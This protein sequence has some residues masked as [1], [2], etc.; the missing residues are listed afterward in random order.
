M[1]F[2]TVLV[3]TLLVLA[4]CS[5]APGN[6]G[7]AGN[8]TSALQSG[9]ATTGES[10]SS[11]ANVSLPPGVSRTGITD[12]NGLATAHALLLNKNSYTVNSTYVERYANGTTRVATSID[13]QLAQNKS[14]YYSVFN[15]SGNVE[16]LLGSPSGSI[17]RW[18]DGRRV[19][20][21]ATLNNST[22]YKVVYDRR[23]N[24]S[25]PRAELFL[26]PTSQNELALLFGAI[27]TSA[28]QPVTRNGTALFRFRS[29]GLS[30]ANLF[31]SAQ[32]VSSPGNV[33]FVAYVD[34]RGLVHE[35]SLS[36]T[37]R[38]D[39]TPI[40]VNRTVR[41][42]DVGSTTVPRPNW[43]SKVPVNGTNA[44]TRSG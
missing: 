2:R 35:Y 18:S 31:T 42:S 37:A 3:A 27:N 13:A 15:A 10:G 40:T 16:R 5:G 19:Y 9:N 22:T 26:N 33:S 23:T 34:S 14:H 6:V 11:A 1:G 17:Q 7:S 30:Q 21:A 39:G 28:P 24:V 12:P 36:Y 25:S 8:A 43:I 38:N 41:Y 44:T 29:V 4:G 32:G 20:Q